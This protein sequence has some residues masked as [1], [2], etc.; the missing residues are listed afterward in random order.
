[1]VPEL[2][3]G[4]AAQLLGDGYEG[5]AEWKRTWSELPPAAFAGAVGA[6]SGREDLLARAGEVRPPALVVH[7]ERDAGVPVAEGRALADALGAELVVVPGAGHGAA[8]THPEP[9]TAAIER[10]LTGVSWSRAAAAPGA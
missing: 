4:L 7:G 3:D 10:F 1:M 9:V 6:L 5:A 2:A 8:L